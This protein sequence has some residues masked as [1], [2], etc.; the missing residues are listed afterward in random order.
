[1]VWL[2]L[3]TDPSS[4]GAGP[5]PEHRVAPGPFTFQPLWGAR[6]SEACLGVRARCGQASTTLT[7]GNRR[8]LFSA[9]P[10]PFPS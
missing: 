1:M 10:A 5:C 4:L 2:A 9:W 6:P 7:K 3:C 8:V